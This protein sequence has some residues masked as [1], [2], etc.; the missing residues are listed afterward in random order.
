MACFFF[1]FSEAAVVTAVEKAE[2]KNEA[3]CTAY[4]IIFR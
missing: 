2:E 4:I 1:F 3:E